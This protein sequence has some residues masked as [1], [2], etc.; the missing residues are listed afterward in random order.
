[1]FPKLVMYAVILNIFKQHSFRCNHPQ[2]TFFDEVDM[3]PLCIR[4]HRNMTRRKIIKIPAN[5]A[6]GH[7]KFPL[8]AWTSTAR[9]EEHAREPDE[10][11][12]MMRRSNGVCSCIEPLH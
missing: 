9:Y 3:A 4:V 7:G 1:M 6:M 10:F 12:F 5:I 8:K 11:Y 2:P